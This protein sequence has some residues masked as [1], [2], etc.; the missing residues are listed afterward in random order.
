[1]RALRAARCAAPRAMPYAMLTRGAP[2][3]AF[4]S[5][6][7]AAAAAPP[8]ERSAAMPGDASRASA[9]SS[10]I[11]ARWRHDIRAALCARGERAVV[12]QRR[13]WRDMRCE[14]RRA[15]PCHACFTLRCLLAFR[16]HAAAPRFS[17]AMIRHTLIFSRRA[18]PPY[19]R[20]RVDAIC[21]PAPALC[22]AMRG[23]SAPRRALRCVFAR[24][25]RLPSCA[26]YMRSA[27]SARH[28]R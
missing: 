12:A 22:A 26:R 19:M 28:T 6:A 14:A 2:A 17:P 21:L 25:Q 16:R 20:W 23:S 4:V 10:H 9:T 7:R 1:M 24:Q 3:L 8:R 15:T 5:A 27:P 11:G 13:R 18:T